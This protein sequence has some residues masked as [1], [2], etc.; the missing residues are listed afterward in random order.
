MQDCWIVTHNYFINF[1]EEL[2]PVWAKHTVGK[3]LFTNMLLD[4]MRN[5]SSV[6]KQ[7]KRH[8]ITLLGK[9]SLATSLITYHK[10]FLK[11]TIDFKDSSRSYT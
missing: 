2:F 5:V 4:N 3:L 9:I 6:K 1:V 10:Q 11:L 7:L 8:S